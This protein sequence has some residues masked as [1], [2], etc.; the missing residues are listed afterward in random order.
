[1]KYFLLLC[2]AFAVFANEVEFELAP[3]NEKLDR[4]NGMLDAHIQKQYD[5]VATCLKDLMTVEGALNTLLDDIK[6][7]NIIKVISDF[8]TDK[9]DLE[10][11]LKDCEN[12]SGAREG[13]NIAPINCIKDIKDTISKVTTFIDDIKNFK[14]TNIMQIIQD[15]IAVEKD[16][17]A[18][19]ADCAL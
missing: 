11:A 14:I 7:G 16:V 17:E 8:A 18:C 1:M 5:D 9:T 19:E 3:F 4:L 12:V 13:E 10:Q 15:G 2:L 6:S